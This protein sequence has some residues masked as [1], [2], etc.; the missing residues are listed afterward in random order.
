MS[1]LPERDDDLVDQRVAQAADL[2]VAT[3]CPC[4]PRP[5]AVS[6]IG[7]AAGARSV[8]DHTPTTAFAASAPDDGLA[9]AGHL[10]LGHLQDDRVDV[11][12]REVV[13]AAARVARAVA[14]VDRVERRPEV[15]EERVVDLAGE[16]L[17]AA[18]QR[19]RSP[20]SATAS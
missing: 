11:V 1:F 13:L 10:G 20:A 3:S 2:D 9:V 17:A 12:A 15:D 6:P 18:V 5:D 19:A 16:H 14:D 7:P 8:V 4:A